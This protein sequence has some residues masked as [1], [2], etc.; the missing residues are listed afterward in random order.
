[1]AKLDAAAARKAP[2]VLTMIT[3]AD[4]KAAGLGDLPC[5]GVVPNRDGSAMTVPPRPIVALDTV[6]FVGDTVAVVV[7]ETL[8]Q[9][10][11]AAE[12]ID[13]QYDTLPAVVGT[14]E[15]RDAK[16]PRVWPHAQGNLAMDWGIGQT[17]GAL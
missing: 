17:R 9:A 4:V 12:M 2:G 13:V 14:M 1:I 16:A 6:R 5:Y 3:G 11:D 10:R 7:A 8:A 15:A